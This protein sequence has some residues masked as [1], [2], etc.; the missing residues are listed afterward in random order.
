MNVTL[1]L[2][3]PRALFA[4]ALPG[5]GLPVGAAPARERP[6]LRATW[7]RDAATGRL[8]CRWSRETGGQNDNEAEEP[9]ARLPQAA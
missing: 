1:F 5:F 7:H 8:V 6:V 9:L 4:R 2:R 3:G